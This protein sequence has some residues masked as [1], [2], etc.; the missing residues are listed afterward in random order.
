MATRSP[1]AGSS[2]SS[3]ARHGRRFF[4]R[5]ARVLARALLGT[6]LRVRG[7]D[8]PRSV[9]IV[10]SEAYVRGD[11]ASHAFRGPT[12]R[13]GAMF[14]PPGTLYLFRIH[15]VDCANV[16]ARR[17]EAVLIR[18]GRSPAASPAT[19]SGPGRLA[20]FLGLGLADDGRDL[21]RDARVALFGR[22]RRPA[23]IRVGRRIGIRQ[24]AERPLRFWIAG[25][26][27]VT[28]PRA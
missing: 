24:G 1:T 18:A 25:E 4:D 19:T 8:G 10:E 26:P 9:E 21:A 12:R 13:N 15:Q 5:P 3:P 27:A 22:R 6:R 14:G 2:S 23:R 16:V 17:G 11:P 7:P 28:P 20:R